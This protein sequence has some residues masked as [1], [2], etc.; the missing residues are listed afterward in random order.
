MVPAWP[1]WIWRHLIRR[2]GMQRMQT[3]Q[4]HVYMCWCVQGGSAALGQEGEAAGARAAGRGGGRPA[5]ARRCRRHGRHTQA[6]SAPAARRE[7]RQRAERAIQPGRALS[8]RTH[9][10]HGP[11]ANRL[12]GGRVQSARPAPARH[13]TRAPAL[14]RPP[15]DQNPLHLGSRE[16]AVY[17]TECHK[18]LLSPLVGRLERLCMSSWSWPQSYTIES[19]LLQEHVQCCMCEK[20][21]E[22]ALAATDCLVYVLCSPPETA[23]ARVQGTVPAA[24]TGCCPTQASQPLS[25]TAQLQ[26]LRAGSSLWV[27]C[28]VARCDHTQYNSQAHR[29]NSIA[30]SYWEAT[31]LKWVN[32]STA[33]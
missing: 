5:G 3:W 22:R 31:Q 32:C 2:A 17:T 20:C 1:C 10:A 23:R 7:Q 13:H 28:P 16:H 27:P 11:A 14:L 9:T 6:A 24:W 26:R 18:G 33:L 19:G 30:C 21:A 12:E 29:A 25:P 8:Q 4:N 15:G